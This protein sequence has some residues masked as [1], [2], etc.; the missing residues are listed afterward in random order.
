MDVLQMKKSDCPSCGTDANF[1]YLQYEHQTKTAVLCGRESVQIRPA[2]KEDRDLDQLA[3]TLKRTGGDVKAN[4]FLVSF[5]V[6]EE[7][8]VM[9]K[10]GRALIHGTNDTK[11]ARILYHRYLS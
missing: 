7:R 3:E 1:P 9:F 11:K 10:D 2:T 8:M 4:P 6:G 5:A